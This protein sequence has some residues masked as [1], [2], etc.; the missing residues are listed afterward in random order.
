LIQKKERYVKYSK[1]KKYLDFFLSAILGIIIGSI[2]MNKRNKKIL[3]N[4][5]N[6]SNKHLKLFLMMNEWVKIKQEGKSL[7]DYMRQNGYKEIAVYG[8]SYVGERLLNEFK[9]SEI[10]IKY[11]IDKNIDKGIFNRN[12][13]TLNDKLENVDAIIVTAVS[14]MD[15]IN[16]ELKGKVLCPIISL[17]DIIYEV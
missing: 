9:N 11:V 10:D 13:K 16:N 5:W 3:S 2:I 12:I 4:V 17:E 6:L 15:E 7:I 14:F 1:N 8:M